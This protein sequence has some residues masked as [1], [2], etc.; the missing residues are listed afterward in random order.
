MDPSSRTRSW[1]RRTRMFHMCNAAFMSRRRSRPGALQSK[2]TLFCSVNN[3]PLVLDQLTLTAS[4][5][6]NHSKANLDLFCFLLHS[7]KIS[8]L[9]R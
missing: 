1:C 8:A 4:L 9:F 5:G 7:G 3:E 2:D 6:K